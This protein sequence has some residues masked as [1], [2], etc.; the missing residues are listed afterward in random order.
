MSRETIDSVDVIGWTLIVVLT[1]VLPI[2]G[3]WFK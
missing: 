3:I 2:L 1:V